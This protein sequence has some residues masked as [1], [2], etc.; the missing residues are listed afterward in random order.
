MEKYD[1]IFFCATITT[2][3]WFF[4]IICSYFYRKKC[5]Y[6]HYD[7]RLD[8][9]SFLC[10]LSFLVTLGGIF[11]ALFKAFHE[12]ILYSIVQM[13]LVVIVLIGLCFYILYRYKLVNGKGNDGIIKQY[14]YAKL[15][16]S[17]FIAAFNAVAYY[18]LELDTSV[19]V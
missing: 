14:K 15:I 6:E 19:L 1:F 17:I 16:L 5:G 9:I 10:R 11:V 3:I 8:K 18:G 2:V 12:H 13:I 7:F 4:M